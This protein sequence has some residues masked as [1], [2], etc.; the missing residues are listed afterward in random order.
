VTGRELSDNSR[1]ALGTGG[2]SLANVDV[3]FGIVTILTFIKSTNIEMSVFDLS[4]LSEFLAPEIQGASIDAHRRPCLSRL[5][6]LCLQDEDARSN[7]RPDGPGGETADVSP[8]RMRFLSLPACQ[9]I[10][11]RKNQCF[12]FVQ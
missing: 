1:C 3:E 8:G 7:G 10:E 2:F 4:D 9:I 11:S 5:V 6:T 12:H